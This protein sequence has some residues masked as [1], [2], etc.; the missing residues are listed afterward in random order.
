[1]GNLI[2]VEGLID[3]DFDMDNAMKKLEKRL[4][5]F[6]QKAPS[7]MAYALNQAAMQARREDAKAA[8]A[9][10]TAEN[11]KEFNLKNVMNI[12][13]R[14]RAGNLSLEMSTGKRNMYG[15][16]KHSVSPRTLSHDGGRKSGPTYKGK[17]LKSSTRKPLF[18]STIED[19]GKPADT[20]NSGDGS[21]S[22]GFIVEFS[23]G[24]KAVVYRIRNQKMRERPGRLTK[25]NMALWESHAPGMAQMA[26]RAFEEKTVQDAIKDTMD[27]ALTQKVA[28]VLKGG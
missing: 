17:V 20:V 18:A 27:K 24:H 26:G 6:S 15:F 25:H 1:M 14:A 13:K 5:P 28:Q 8:K 16:Y 19:N 12:T 4:G 21:A 11:S 3:F 23:S 22:R 2:Q 10:Y 9:R 7:V